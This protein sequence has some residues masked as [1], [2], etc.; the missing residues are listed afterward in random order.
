MYKISA[1][2]SPELEVTHVEGNYMIDGKAVNF[3]SVINSDGT[4]HVLFNGKSFTIDVIEKLDDGLL[5]SI[6]KK[7]TKV[8]IKNELE[9][10]LS[11]LGM[12]KDHGALI[13]ELKAPMPGMVLKVMVNAGDTVKKGES[14][15]VLEAMKMENN[16]KSPGDGTVS[17][18]CIS[19]GDK[20]EKN[21]VLIKF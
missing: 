20:V 10:L 15:L 1:N 5:L 19:A 14:L 2:E 21:Q 12:D 7:K 9:D 11:K 18:V 6:N 13:N 17:Q 4:Y 3:D 16:I 8:K